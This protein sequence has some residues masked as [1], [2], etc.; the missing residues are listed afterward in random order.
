[1]II[2]WLRQILRLNTEKYYSKFEL[3]HYAKFEKA[4]AESDVV[5]DIIEAQG[6]SEVVVQKN[7]ELHPV[8]IAN[9][10][11]FYKLNRYARRKMLW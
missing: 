8:T 3:E 5:V 11:Q 6:F 7:S 10:I 2:Q 4:L 9:L 1:M